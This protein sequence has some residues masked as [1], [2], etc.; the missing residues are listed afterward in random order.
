MQFHSTCYITDKA[1][2][3]ESHVLRISQNHEKRGDY[4]YRHTAY[5]QIPSFYVKFHKH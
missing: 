4:T 5:N 1:G 3:A 2:N